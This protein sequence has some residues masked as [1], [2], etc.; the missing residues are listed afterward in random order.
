MTPHW[1]KV[2]SLCCP[3]LPAAQAV[4]KFRPRLTSLL[5]GAAL[6][7]L[8]CAGSAAVLA[9]PAAAASSG[10]VVN[11]VYGGGG[12]S[13]ATLTNDFI[14]LANIGTADN[15]AYQVVHLNAEFANQV[16]D[17]DPQVV[18]ISP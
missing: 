8:T 12:N 9:P 6:G 4:R 13:G 2:S 7:A 10:A 14:E 5:A 15:F 18:D 17:H 1:F 16:S 3:I 11:E